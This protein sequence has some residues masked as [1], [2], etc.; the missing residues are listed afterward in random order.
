MN[1]SLVYKIFIID[2]LFYAEKSK[3]KYFI[4][5]IY[6]SCIFLFEFT[7]EILFNEYFAVHIKVIKFTIKIT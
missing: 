5:I 3:N 2:F 1:N 6:F 4:S 7:K